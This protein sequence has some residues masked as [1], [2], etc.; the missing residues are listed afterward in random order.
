MKSVIALSA[1]VASVAAFS[2]T[3]QSTSSSSTQ[4]A[5]TKD[6]LK[7][8]APK[9]NP[10]VPFFDPLQLCDAAF[11]GQSNEFTIG[12]LRQAEIK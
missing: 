3:Q 4:L 7:A 5:E 10:I 8:L 6:D 12:W 2:P 9:L 1:M 11:W